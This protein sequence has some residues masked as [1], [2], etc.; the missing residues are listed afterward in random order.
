MNQLTLS[1][2][3][4]QAQKKCV[5][6]DVRK[7]L[8][9]WYEV[10][11]LFKIRWKQCTPHVTVYYSRDTSQAHLRTQYTGS[12]FLKCI[13][14]LYTDSWFLKCIWPIQF[15]VLIEVWWQECVPG[16]GHTPRHLKL[17]FV[18]CRFLFCYSLFWVQIAIS[19]KLGT[20]TGRGDHSI[21]S[22][23]CCALAP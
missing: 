15:L 14:P 10:S 21:F 13:W 11:E 9:T 7:C 8:T 16:H 17:Q 19:S 12:L 23:F 2:K 4:L 6:Y 18:S 1:D 5:I 3:L 20:G 22:I